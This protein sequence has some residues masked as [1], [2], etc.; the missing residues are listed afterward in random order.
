[1]NINHS[2]CNHN[3]YMSRRNIIISMAATAIS[4][5]AAITSS[6]QNTTKLTATKANDYGLVYTLPS[7][8][9]N[10]TL[11]A[12]RTE[13]R[14]GEFYNYATKYLKTS[15]IQSKS[16]KWTL[17]G[18]QLT[19]TAVPDD[20]QRYNV[21]VKSG[22]PVTIVIDS[23]HAT[24]SINDEGYAPQP[25]EKPP[26]HPRQAQPSIHATPAARQAMTEEMIQS[27]STA[28]RA[29]LAADKIFELRQNRNDIISGNA[30]GMPKDGQAMQLA[31]DNLTQ[32]EEALTA[33]F[34]GV[35]VSSSEI[36]TYTF[37]PGEESQKIVIARIS[38][39]KGLIAADDLAGDPIYLNYKV[40][41]K[42]TMP[43]T[44]KGEERRFPKGG[45]AYRIPGT[46]EISIIYDGKEL[47]KKTLHI[48]QLGVV[49]GMEPS[50]FSDKKTPGYA[51]FDPLTGAIKETGIA[52]VNR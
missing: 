14:P 18:V 25:A 12:E 2:T 16:Q 22:T 13:S 17:S 34:T 11:E 5:S 47:D 36:A 31:L 49:F 42:G 50:M 37:V 19:Q 51:H 41:S 4:L 30:D 15:P 32:Q 24:V 33:M 45:V 10:V 38:P 44:D 23:Y 26:L 48:P 39:V 27:T 29:E 28:K 6:A 1:M 46:A 20:E 35:T 52:T 3:L 7:A 43:L 9:I 21:Q 8:V 40:V